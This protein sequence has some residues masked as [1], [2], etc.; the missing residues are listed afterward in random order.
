MNCAAQAS[1]YFYAEYV[2][3]KYRE[4]RG[5]ALIKMCSW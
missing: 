1:I 5:K 2:L 3:E 4:G